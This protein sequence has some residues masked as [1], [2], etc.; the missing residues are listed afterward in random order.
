MTV[1]RVINGTGPVRPTTRARVLAAI[2]ELGYR[3]NSAAR[4]LVTGRTGTLG[5][6]ALESNLYGPASTLYGIENAAREAG[7]AITISSVSRARP[8]SIADAVENLRG[9]AVEGIVVI[10]PHVTAGRA[11]EAAPADVPLVAVG[12]G[13]DA[14]VPVI[15]VDQHAGARRPPNTYSRWATA[16]CGT[17]PGQGLAGS[18]EPRAPAGAPRWSAPAPKCPPPARRL[19]PGVPGTRPAGCSASMPGVTAVFVANDSMALGR[20]ARVPRAGPRRAGRRERR[21]VRRRTG[22]RLL[23][24]AA[25]HDPTGLRGGR[26]PQPRRCWSSRSNGATEHDRAWSKPG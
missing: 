18:A 10:A 11:L 22:G 21:R 15:A 14:P 19:E 17:S 20:A 26:P 2:E 24:P 25:D 3:P 1:S 7:Y 23:H 16:P 4:A 6:V 13:D 12:G 9:Q 5:V 8:S